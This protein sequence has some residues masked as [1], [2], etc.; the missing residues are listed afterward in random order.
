[1]SI[2]NVPAFR[3]LTG[4][5]EPS[6]VLQLPDGRLLVVEDERE[7]PLSLVTLRVDGQSWTRRSGR[8]KTDQTQVLACRR[9]GRRGADHTGAKANRGQA[10]RDAG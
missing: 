6:A 1:M 8:Q 4:I 5:Y 3:P 2:A 10:F 9:M 7:H